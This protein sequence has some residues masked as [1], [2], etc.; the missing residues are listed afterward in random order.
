MPWSIE[1]AP[2]EIVAAFLRG[3]FDADGCAVYD[4]SKGSLRRAR[5]RSRASLL[6]GVQRLLTTF[7]V[8]SRIYHDAAARRRPAFAY[9]APDGTDRR[10]TTG[11][12]MLRP[13]DHRR[14]RSTASPTTIGFTVSSQGGKLRRPSSLGRTPATQPTT[15]LRLVERTDDGV[16]LTY[17]LSEPRNHSYVANGVLVRNCCEYIH[18]DNT[19]CN[20]AA[21]TC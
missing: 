7:G 16:E 21:S 8:S 9:D 15:T 2:P 4:G 14:D 17:N 13:S 6:R 5:A 18:L 19:A 3:L 12:A 11:D 1:Q 20:L 10:S